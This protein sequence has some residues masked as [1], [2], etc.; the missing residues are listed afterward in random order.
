LALLFY[1]AVFVSLMALRYRTATGGR[2]S[3]KRDTQGRAYYEGFSITDTLT[4]SPETP[5]NHRNVLNLGLKLDRP[6]FFRIRRTSALLDPLELLGLAKYIDGIPGAGLVFVGEHPDDLHELIDNPSV[7]EA[8]DEIFMDYH[9]EKIVCFGRKIWV[10][11][12]GMSL[13][14]YD[15]TVR[16]ALL[17]RLSKIARVAKENAEKR[18]GTK[19]EFHGALRL[20]WV[21]AAHLLLL[22]GGILAA[23]SLI[24]ENT[25][26]LFLQPHIFWIVALCLAV[27]LS[28]LWVAALYKFLRRTMWTTLALMDFIL[29]GLTGIVLLSVAGI[30]AANRHLPQPP[31]VH[32]NSHVKH[33]LCN[34][35]CYATLQS[36]GPSP[37]SGGQ[38]A[39]A[40]SDV[41]WSGEECRPENR[42]RFVIDMRKES[43]CIERIDYN[44]TLWTALIP[45]LDRPLVLR[46]TQ[47]EFDKITTGDPIRIPLYRG[48]LGLRWVDKDGWH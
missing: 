44:F 19:R 12:R 7:K 18:E 24:I 47:E 29:I 28:A 25:S 27:L 45:E 26:Y 23:F 16:D 38:F 32:I 22:G 4:K 21:M 41:N 5:H 42:R 13:E 48:A 30:H 11:L 14:N 8:I 31:A 40:P 15:E 33:A 17:D 10:R 34:I 3:E 46:V 39:G 35:R 9:A 6:A 20:P 1:I 37:G 2:L 36:E 43:R